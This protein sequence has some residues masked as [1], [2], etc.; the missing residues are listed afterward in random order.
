LALGLAGQSRDFAVFP[1][2]RTPAGSPISWRRSEVCNKESTASWTP[3][4]PGSVSAL[5]FIAGSGSGGRY[6]ALQ[7]FT[8]RLENL[9]EA[10]ARNQKT[11]IEI[12]E[13]LRE[14]LNDSEPNN[15]NSQH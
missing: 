2:S 1:S 13:I 10:A 4:E 9:D 15:G 8:E 14:R 3:I 11:R 7:S 12:Y 6:R 5:A